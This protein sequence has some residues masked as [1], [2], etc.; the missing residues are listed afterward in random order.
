MSDSTEHEKWLAAARS[1][2]GVALGRLLDAYRNRLR[3]TVDADIHGPLQRRID[4]SDIVQQAWVQAVRKFNQF[5]GTTLA[6]FWRWLEQVERNILVDVVREHGAQRR[7]AH[8]EQSGDGHRNAVGQFTTAS[9]KVMRGERRRELERAIDQ[10]PDG[11]QEAIRLR[12]LHELKVAEIAQQMER[13]EEAVAG[14]LK[15]GVKTLKD[16]LSDRSL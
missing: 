5:Q 10:L 2:D 16:I 13:S 4:A 9:Q 14:L 15:R 12:Y 8:A 11:Q 1:G 3:E 7:D 6:E